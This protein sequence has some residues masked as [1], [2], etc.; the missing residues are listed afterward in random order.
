VRARKGGGVAAGIPAR[1]VDVLAAYPYVGRPFPDELEGHTY[2]EFYVP[3][4]GWIPVNPQPG[5]IVGVP[6]ED[7]V[8]LYHYAMNRKWNGR[9]AKEIH[10]LCT[11]S[12]LGVTKTKFIVPRE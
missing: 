3:G 9:N 7:C 10:P 11:L 4:A 2:G 8:R 5:G 12:Q 1:M 6:Q